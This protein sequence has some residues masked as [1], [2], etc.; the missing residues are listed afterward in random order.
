MDTEDTKEEQ[1]NEKNED[2]DSTRFVDISFY[3]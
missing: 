3:R 2:Q 1:K